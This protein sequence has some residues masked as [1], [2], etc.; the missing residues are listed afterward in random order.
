MW[1]K[2]GSKEEI[3]AEWKSELTTKGDQELMK[4][5]GKWT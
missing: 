5:I 3:R 2:N 1:I 4:V